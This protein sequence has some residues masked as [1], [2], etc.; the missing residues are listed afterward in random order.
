MRGRILRGLA[1]TAAG[2][3]TVGAGF[4]ATADGSS[5]NTNYRLPFGLGVFRASCSPGLTESPASIMKFGYPSRENVKHRNGYVLSYNTVHKTA[6]WTCEHLTKAKVGARSASRESSVFTEDPSVHPFFRSNDADYR[7]SGFDRGHLVPAGDQRDSS[8]NM[9]DTF[10]YSNMSPQVGK[11]F[12][13]D[14]WAQ[15][16]CYVRDL[17]N[18]YR[19]VYVM[20]GPLFL[21]RRTP[22]GKKFISYQVIGANNVSVPTHFYKVVAGEKADGSVEIQ[23]FVMPNTELPKKVRVSSFL[24][25]LETVE[26]QSGLLFFELIP[27]KY[28]K[29]K[30]DNNNRLASYEK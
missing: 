25:P 24:V 3:L 14:G 10:Y 17:V 5:S 20:T 18:V 29:V 30:R 2:G 8:A 12:N 15:L 22:D 9:S 19:D 13:R 21:P 1:W 26:K 7:R 4:A 27:N 16:E 23:A 11:G 6:N 28:A